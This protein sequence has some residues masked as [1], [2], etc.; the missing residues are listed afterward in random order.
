MTSVLGVDRSLSGTWLDL[1]LCHSW[2]LF[3]HQIC[4]IKEFLSV[5]GRIHLK[6]ASMDSLEWKQREVEVT[7]AGKKMVTAMSR[8]WLS[9]TIKTK[10]WITIYLHRKCWSNWKHRLTQ[11]PASQ[12]K[13]TSV[14]FNIYATKKYLLL[15]IAN[16]VHKCQRS[17]IATWFRMFQSHF[18][19]VAVSSSY[20]M[21]TNLRILKR[22]TVHSARTLRRTKV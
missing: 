22:D 2:N 18:V 8:P 13:L 19:S 3:H 17:I 9:T 10:T 1:I 11:K 6:K 4:L 20:K 5:W 12:L 14:Y 21:N 15:T 16:S 7:M